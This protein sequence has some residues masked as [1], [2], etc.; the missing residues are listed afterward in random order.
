MAELRPNI[1][2]HGRHFVHHL[3]ICNPICV[4]LLQ[5]M[6]GVIPSNLT[7]RTSEAG[8]PTLRKLPYGVRSRY[9]DGTEVPTPGATSRYTVGTVCQRQA[10]EVGIPTLFLMHTGTGIPES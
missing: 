1:V 8:I 5:V 6:S 7:F 3:G 4:K 10:P 9:T 2:F